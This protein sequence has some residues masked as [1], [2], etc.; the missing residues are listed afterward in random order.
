MNPGDYCWHVVAIWF[1]Y[2]I[3]AAMFSRK[4]DR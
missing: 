2:H 3:G 1:A 4:R